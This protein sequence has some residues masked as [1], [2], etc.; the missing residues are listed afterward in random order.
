MHDF[1][2]WK[3]SKIRLDKEQEF[4]GDKGYQG[5]QKLHQKSRT[6]HKK[7]KNKKLT[8]EEKKANRQLAFVA[9]N[10]RTYSSPSQKISDTFVPI[11][12]SKKTIGF[13][14]QFDCWYL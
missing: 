13:E 1:L 10:Y 6:P 3:K 14:T 7:R 12:K 2:L 5:I 8:V 9:N 11:Q 4:L